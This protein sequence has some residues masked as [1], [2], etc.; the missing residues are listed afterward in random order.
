MD[1]WGPRWPY[2]WFDN[3]GPG[4]SIHSRSVSKP[5]LITVIR[6]VY[7]DITADSTLALTKTAEPKLSQKFIPHPMVGMAAFTPLWSELN[8]FLLVEDV[9]F[10]SLSDLVIYDK[11]KAEHSSSPGLLQPVPIPKVPWRD[12]VMDFIERLPSVGRK[13]TTLVVIDPTSKYAHFWVVPH[14]YTT[15]TI[16]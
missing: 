10:S 4:F 15:L 12:I 5:Q 3:S 1:Y 7:F 9:M 8:T 13:P 16:V 11:D 14:P 6:R 2:W